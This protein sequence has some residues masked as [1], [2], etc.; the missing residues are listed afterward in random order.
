MGKRNAAMNASAKIAASSGS[1]RSYT[2]NQPARKTSVSEDRP[3]EGGG[4]VAPPR[5]RCSCIRSSLADSRPRTTQVRRQVGDHLLIEEEGCFFPCEVL[6]VVDAA[7]GIWLVHYLGWDDIRDE[8]V[9]GKGSGARVMPDTPENRLLCADL[10]A[11]IRRIQRKGNQLPRVRS[12]ASP[13]C[14]AAAAAAG[15]CCC[16][17]RCWRALA[18]QRAAAYSRICGLSLG[19]PCCAN[20]ARQS[21]S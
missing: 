18:E 6:K 21:L 10:T 12:A 4:S 11:Q 20:R 3:R 2:E 7:K 1:S 15:S 17:C 5:R 14:F 16:R 9:G 8:K 13:A 19:C